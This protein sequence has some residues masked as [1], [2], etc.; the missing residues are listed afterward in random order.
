MICFLLQ[1]GYASF[2]DFMRYDYDILWD[3]YDFEWKFFVSIIFPGKFYN[4]PIL[5]GGRHALPGWCAYGT[6]QI[7]VLKKNF[8]PG[9]INYLEFAIVKIDYT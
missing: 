9:K 7:P 8:F 3:Y 2:I 4:S 1:Q 5:N 6:K